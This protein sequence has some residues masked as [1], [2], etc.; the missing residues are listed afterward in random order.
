MGD[1]IQG[2]WKKRT[3]RQIVEHE[4]LMLS[5]S[6]AEDN[7]LSTEPSRW[8][9]ARKALRAASSPGGEAQR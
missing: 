7:R 8:P 4:I 2:P 9:P 5:Q 6:L 1:V 3:A